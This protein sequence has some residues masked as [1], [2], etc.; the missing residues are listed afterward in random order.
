[1]VINAKEV[2]LVLPALESLGA[3]MLHSA[4]EGWIHPSQ[5][6]LDALPGGEVLKSCANHVGRVKLTTST[7]AQ[8]QN[9]TT[10]MSR[11]VMALRYHST[12]S[13]FRQV[14]F[15]EPLAYMR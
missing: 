9:L 1:L 8:A 5:D 10:L 7:L 4:S 15:L 13:L 2:Q 3:E 11:K 14:I 12:V 6:D